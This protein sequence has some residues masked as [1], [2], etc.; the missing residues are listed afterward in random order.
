MHT[1]I[2]YSK[3]FKLISDQS[4]LISKTLCLFAV[5]ASNGKI[6]FLCWLE[7][8]YRPL[9]YPPAHASLQFPFARSSSSLV[10]R[11]LVY[12]STG[13]PTSQ[14]HPAKFAQYT[15]ANS[16]PPPVRTTSI[17]L[18]THILDT[19]LDCASYTGLWELSSSVRICW[20]LEVDAPGWKE[21]KIHFFNNPQ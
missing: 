16:K 1:Y 11:V 10:A 8:G 21:R 2:Y 12:A 19:R 7:E 18:F 15:V 6:I 17:F 14:H 13:E 5:C 4:S 3:N 9:Y 20:T